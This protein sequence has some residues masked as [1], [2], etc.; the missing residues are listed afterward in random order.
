LMSKMIARQINPDHSS[1]GLIDLYLMQ[2]DL[3][4]KIRKN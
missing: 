3:V 2:K 4:V 1:Y